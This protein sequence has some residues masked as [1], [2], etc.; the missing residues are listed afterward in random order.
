ME[1]HEVFAA[2]GEKGFRELVGAF[3]RRVP[4][5]PVLG[6]MY[7]NHD[8]AGAE[9]RLRGFLIYRFGG[10]QTYIEERGHP[11]LRMRHAPFAVNE[12]ARDHWLRLMTAALEETEMPGEAKTVLGNFFRDTASFLINRP[13]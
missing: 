3:Y 7:P 13:S 10:P 9:E 8:F 11:R 2:I 5:D 12:E 1:E 6:P 4:E